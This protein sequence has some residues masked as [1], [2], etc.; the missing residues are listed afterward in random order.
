[1]FFLVTLDLQAFLF[2]DGSETDSVSYYAMMLLEVS[3]IA[4]LLSHSYNLSHQNIKVKFSTYVTT[5][6]LGINLILSIYLT[7]IMLSGDRGAIISFAVVY[8]YAFAVASKKNISKRVL[9][10]A[11]SIGV[12]VV[13]QLGVIRSLSKELSF[14]DRARVVLAQSSRF[15]YTS[16][17]PFTQELASSAR[18]L[19]L[20]VYNV[21]NSNTFFYGRLQIQQIISAIPFAG[22]LN[23]MIFDNTPQYQGSTYYVSWL[24]QGELNGFNGIGSTC[25]ADFYLDFGVIGVALGM[26]IFGYFLRLLDVYSYLRHGNI[27]IFCFSFCYAFFVI[28]IARQSVLMPLKYVILLYIIMKVSSITLFPKVVLSKY[29]KHE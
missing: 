16:V 26:L 7:L 12:F 3:L 11:V 22:F 13:I 24:Y 18:C 29:S 1:M 8:I 28:G 5:L 20:A 4:S 27:L 6:G 21:P 19:N 2:N 17:L 10:F 14:V 9:L 25:I 15:E 23:P